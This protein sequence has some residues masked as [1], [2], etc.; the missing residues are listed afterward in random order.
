[1]R[2]RLT[3]FLALL[4]GA[5]AFGATIYKWVDEH[6]VTHY[7]DQAPPEQD[8]QKIETPTTPAAPAT[9]GTQPPSS[10]SWREREEE[11]QQR[12]RARQLQLDE[13]RRDRRLA[14]ELAEIERGARTPVPGSTGATPALQID[15]LRLLVMMDSAAGPTC[16]THRM[17]N[18]ELVELNRKTRTAVER[19]TLD[20]CGRAVRYQVTFTPA[21]DGGMNFSIQAE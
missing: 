6:G 15:V 16:T 21:R 13:E 3:L 9:E 11:F 17:L 1:M 18:T 5:A 2:K 19:W 7:S 8:A 20:R 4:L 10:D 14:A 12:H